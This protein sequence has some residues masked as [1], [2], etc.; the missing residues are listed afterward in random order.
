KPEVYLPA[1]AR[2]YGDYDNMFDFYTAGTGTDTGWPNKGGRTLLLRRLLM[3]DS[4][5][6]RFI[7]R[8][9][10]LLNGPFREEIVLSTIRQMA[11]VI[12]PEIA[13]HLQRWSWSELQQRGFGLPHQAEYEPFT[14]ETWE[15][16]LGVLMDFAERRPANL[17]QDCI[18]HFGLGGGLA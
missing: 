4:F 16:N 12:R 5:K 18:N 7:K 6:E 14:Q 17:R 9:A 11:Q 3:N 13:R 1:M 8:C 15:K 2:D 10:D